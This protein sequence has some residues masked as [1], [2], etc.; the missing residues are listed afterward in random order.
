MSKSKGNVV[1]TDE[2]LD[3]YSIDHFRYWVGSA[4][5][6]TDIPFKEQD[7]VAGQKFITKL[8][9]A[10]KFSIGMLKGYEDKNLE[11]EAFDKWLL[12]KLN[13]LVKE[14]N[15]YFEKYNTGDAKRKTEYFFWHTFCDNYLEI[16]KD[17]MYNPDKRGENAKTSAQKTLSNSILVMLKLFAPITPYITEEIYQLYFAK[18][19]KMKSVHISSWPEYN[20][21][22]ID[23]KAEEIGDKLVEVIALV[24]KKKSENNL[25][26]KESVKEIVLDLSEEEVKPFLEDLKS[27]TK[28]KKISF[29]KKVSVKL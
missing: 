8:W 24:R 17:R 28:A 3:K 27:V 2:I 1:W 20:S 15:S 5:W 10:S 25:S 9:N 11:L 6:G 16:I 18:K 22:F 23:E 13:N 21:K 14:N 4:R 7:L 26:L 19:E 12:S 29:G